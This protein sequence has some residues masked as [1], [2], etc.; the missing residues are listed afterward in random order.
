M[1]RRSLLVAGLAGTSVGLAATAQARPAPDIVS[2]SQRS[3]P[4]GAPGRVALPSLKPIWSESVRKSFGVCAHPNFGDS[5]YQFTDAWVAALAETGASYFRGQYSHNLTATDVAI[6]S[7]RR[8]GLRWG[9]TV[10]PENWAVTGPA[11]VQR[12][13]HIAD[14]AADV[15][16]YV[17]G[18]NE[19]NHERG[20]GRAP[21]DWISRTMAVQRTIWDAVK[22]D[23]RLRHVQV[24][25]P[26]LHAVLATEADYRQI[27]QAGLA[28]YMDYAAIHRYPNGRY[29]NHLLDEKLGWVARHW[30]GKPTWI[31]ETGY[32]NAMGTNLGHRPVPEDVAAVYA[33]SAILEAAD[34]GCMITW[35][36]LLDDVDGAAKANIESNF[37]MFA[38]R[39]RI[40]PP[41]RPKPVVASV[42]SFL[43]SLRDPGPTFDPPQIGL[44]IT[45]D[46]EDVRSTIIAKRDGS[47]T[48][49]LRRATEG[50]D[51]IAKRPIRVDEVPVVVHSARTQRTV[52]V[53]HEVQ[54]V[55]I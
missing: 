41:W 10:V 6:A 49:Y 40:G 32:T 48:V 27:G 37:G 30:G 44:R 18:I 51:R 45:T 15:C 34:R 46:A 22:G 54:A 31:T 33:P 13:R 2:G 24:L 14:N 43:D 47:A 21:S 16:L 23:P 17:E 12:I 28:N 25:G 36:E 38:A 52:W 26:S 9:M 20:G 55:A 11:L 5:Q 19:P 8:R 35:Y 42:R 1:S 7:S 53:D 4:R 50:W 3:G 29:P 39:G